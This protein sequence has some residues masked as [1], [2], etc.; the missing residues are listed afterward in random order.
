MEKEQNLQEPQKQALNI[1]VVMQQ[2]ELFVSFARFVQNYKH[3]Y[4][5]AYE[6][7]FSEWL[8]KRNK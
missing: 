7:M 3:S 1:P 8:K 5:V 4:G 6:D 2:R